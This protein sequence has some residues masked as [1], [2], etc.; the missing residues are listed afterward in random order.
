[1]SKI[2]KL[3]WDNIYTESKITLKYKFEE[4]TEIC[5]FVNISTNL[6]FFLIE[7]LFIM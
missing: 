3:G 7:K 1:M 6:C 5:P 4:K 2:K